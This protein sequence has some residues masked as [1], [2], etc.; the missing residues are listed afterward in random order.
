MRILSK[1]TYLPTPNV[2]T[3]ECIWNNLNANM[4]GKSRSDHI[5]SPLYQCWNYTNLSLT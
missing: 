4:Q 3:E 5:V 1:T 2:F